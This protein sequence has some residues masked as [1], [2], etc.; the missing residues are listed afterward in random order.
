MTPLHLQPPQREGQVSFP[1]PSFSESPEGLGT[2]SGLAETDRGCAGVWGETVSCTRRC[3]CVHFAD[4]ET[5]VQGGQWLAQ[6]H[7]SVRIKTQAVHL[8][9]SIPGPIGPAERFM[10]TGSSLHPVT[11]EGWCINTPPLSPP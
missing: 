4:V 2:S 7:A 3:C 8:V 9:C 10:P 11:G 5:E 1:F 6:G